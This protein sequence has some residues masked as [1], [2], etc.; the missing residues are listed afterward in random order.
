MK[1]SKRK[2]ALKPEISAMIW[3]FAGNYIRIGKNID[4]RQNLLN[5]AVT[6]W[7]I[8]LLK[9]EYREKA[10][11]TYLDK[12]Q[13]LN[14]NENEEYRINLEKDLRLLLT[15]KD[16]LFP[17]VIKQIAHAEIRHDDGMDNITVVSMK[18]E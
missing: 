18:K 3:E 14:P 15:E 17:S 8:S 1:K 10:I 7:N 5:S 2:N 16:R 9:D 6:V 4:Q 13:E 12:C 11:K